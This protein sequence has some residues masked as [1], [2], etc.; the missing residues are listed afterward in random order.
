[1]ICGRK[2]VFI[3]VVDTDL[4]PA[5]PSESES[6]VLMTKNLRKTKTK[7]KTAIYLSL[8]LHKGRPSYRSGQPS[9]LKREQL[10]LQKMKLI[11]FF[12]FL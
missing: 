1:M 9:A 6:S 8:G 4:D 3:S 11:N 12:Q 7:T 2:L 5:L 10:A